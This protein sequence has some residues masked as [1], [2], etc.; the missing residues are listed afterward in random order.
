VGAYRVLRFLSPWTVLSF[1][2]SRYPK[3]CDFS[4]SLTAASFLRRLLAQPSACSLSRTSHSIIPTSAIFQTLRQPANRS[5][6]RRCDRPPHWNTF[7]KLASVSSR[8]DS[9]Y[10]TTLSIPIC[11]QPRNRIIGGFLVTTRHSTAARRPR[12]YDTSFAFH[13]HPTSGVTDSKL[14]KLFH[15]FFVRLPVPSTNAF[16]KIAFNHCIITARF[17]YKIVVA[18]RWDLCTF[19]EL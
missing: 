16:D 19:A 12:R 1:L 7:P 11:T 4:H 3:F 9:S 10:F 8:N 15:D 2:S 18:E 6:F 17:T 5:A 13:P 14:P